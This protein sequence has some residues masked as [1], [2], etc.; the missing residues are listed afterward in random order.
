MPSSTS[1]CLDWSALA[2]RMRART[3]EIDSLMALLIGHADFSAGSKAE[4]YHAA[5]LVACASLGDGHLWQDMGLPSRNA[6][7]AFIQHWF[8]ALSAL[9]ANNMKWKKFFYRQL[10]LQEDILICRS[11]SC[12]D[13]GD[14]E[15][16]FG[17]E[18]P[19]RPHS[20]AA[21][22]TGLNP[23]GVSRRSIGFSQVATPAV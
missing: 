9:N 22:K 21:G 4:V 12:A 18:E 5:W 13:C 20:D 8:P 1:P 15:N 10:C 23:P 3:D 11:P 17:P 19:M 14:H 7:S 2:A 16:C 6:L